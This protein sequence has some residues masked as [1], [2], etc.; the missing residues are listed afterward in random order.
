MPRLAKTALL[1]GTL[2]TLG[3]MALVPYAMALRP[4]VAEQLQSPLPQR[5]L[6]QAIQG[7][8]LFGFLAFVGL[9]AGASQGLGAPLIE[10]RLEG[11]SPVAIHW[12]S[13]GL[14]CASGFTGA[15]GVAALDLLFD[16]QVPEGKHP[17]Y[18]QSLLASL[19]GGITEEVQL[20]VFMM[21]I[22]AW[23]LG[24][25]GPNRH[26]PVWAAIVLSSLLFGAGHL[27]TAFALWGPTAEVII[28]T[29]LLNGIMGLLFGWLYWRRGFCHA[30]V[31][32]FSADISLHIVV[33]LL[34]W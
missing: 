9:R 20:R 24:K 26:W 17:E 12:P 18:W 5:L 2:A 21:S 15:L 1:I 14:A 33:P 6:I 29:L 11:T 13:L 28:R 32:H 16:L 8:V 23:L 30:V 4:E 27:P 7:F 10:S 25:F 31:A 3:A 19:Y 22:I 34:G